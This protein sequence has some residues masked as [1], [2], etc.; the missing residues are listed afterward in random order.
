M[1]LEWKIMNRTVSRQNWTS[2]ANI[3]CGTASLS[4]DD[5]FLDAELVLLV[6]PAV[7][8]RTEDAPGVLLGSQLLLL[9]ARKVVCMHATE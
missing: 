5:V 2:S 7:L 6:S 9:P 4:E 8:P 1:E 3:P